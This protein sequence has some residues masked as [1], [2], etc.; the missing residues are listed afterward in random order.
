MV[1][2]GDTLWDIARMFLTDAW[3]WPEIWH[4]NPGIQNPHLIYPGDEI[5]LSYVDGQPQLSLQ[6]GDASRTDRLSPA[7][8]VGQGD[9]YHKVEPRIRR[10]HVDE[11]DPCHTVGC[12]RKSSNN[13]KYHRAV[14]SAQCVLY[15]FGDSRPIDIWSGG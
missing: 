15:S 13:V 4:V 12:Y 14:S 5:V 10:F 9:R 3:M 6:R 8:T 1:Q 11:R 2:D 7:K